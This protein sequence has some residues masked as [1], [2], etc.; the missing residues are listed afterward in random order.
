M[1][2]I[3]PL[4]EIWNSSLFDIYVLY[5]NLSISLFYQFSGNLT[6]LTRYLVVEYVSE[7]RPGFLFFLNESSS[8]S[9]V[10]R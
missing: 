2:K 7:A 9:A 3:Y 1:L 4:Y 10:Y 6:I 8:P 5:N